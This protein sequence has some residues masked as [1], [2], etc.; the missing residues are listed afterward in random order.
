MGN[1]MLLTILV[2]HNMNIINIINDIST[3]RLGYCYF[4]DVISA[5]NGESLVLY[6]FWWF[7]C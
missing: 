2:T 4:V 3:R 7:S 6:L 5:L 1:F